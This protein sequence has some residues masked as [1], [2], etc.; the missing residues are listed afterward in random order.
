MAGYVDKTLAPDEKIVYRVHFNWTF[1]FFPVLW[2]ALGSA[3]VVMY[4]L[5]H[6]GTFGQK[7]P[8]DEL[9]IGWWFVYGGFVAGLL[10]LLNHM[11]ILWTTEI[12]VTTYRFVFKTG[13]IS[14]S[15]QEVSL[16]KI[17][18]IILHQTV[19]GRIF[20]YGKLTL[21]GTGVGVIEL[22]NVDDPI[23]VRRAIEQAKA[24]L[25][26]TNRDERLDDDD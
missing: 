18:E 5:L 15:T 19:W 25:R 4:S 22:P 26:R 21:R 7:I 23:D 6:F 12:A 1:S 9:R 11:I 13:L 20:G 10:I 16:N 14:R 2:F 24:D 3:P 17:E 8:Y